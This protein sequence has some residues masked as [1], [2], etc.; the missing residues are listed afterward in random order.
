MGV[1]LA[2]S[3]LHSK[4]LE[5]VVVVT[6]VVGVPVAAG[7]K[8]TQ[9]KRCRERRREARIPFAARFSTPWPTFSGGREP[10]RHRGRTLKPGKPGYHLCHLKLE[11]Y[12]CFAFPERVQCH[13]VPVSGVWFAEIDVLVVEVPGIRS[14][15]TFRLNYVE[16][17]RIIG[18]GFCGGWTSVLVGSVWRLL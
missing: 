8:E 18:L 16:V 11:F 9:R 6:G 7:Q 13:V 4:E 15:R 14:F 17:V 12:R 3:Y 1:A 2:F 10:V 5:R